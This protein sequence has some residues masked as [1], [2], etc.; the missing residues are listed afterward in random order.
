MLASEP[1]SDQPRCA[2]PVIAEFLRTYNDRVDED[3]RQDLFA[4]AALAV[5][6]RANHPTERRRA[7][8]CLEWWLSN[9]TPSA[10]RLRRLLW[11]GL[12]GLRARDIEIAYR[13]ARWAAASPDR[14]AAALAL[15]ERLTGSAGDSAVAVPDRR[16]DRRR[17][18][19]DAVR[20]EALED[21][22]RH[23]VLGAAG[24]PQR[25]HEARG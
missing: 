4:Y 6:T 20:F 5:G 24:G 1:F 25:D 9:A 10:P 18:D 17:R 15:V 16:V 23:L 2:C 22:S 12:P 13:A 3:R 19:L 21:P 14:H 11:R 8:A 7:D